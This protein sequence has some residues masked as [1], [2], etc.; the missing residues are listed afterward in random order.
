MKQEVKKAMPMIMLAFVLA[1]SMQEA[2]NIS[3]PLIIKDYAIDSAAVSMIAAVAMLTMGV[4]YVFYTALSDYISIKKLLIIGTLISAV[5]SLG[6][7]FLSQSFIWLVIFRA[8]QMAGGTSASALLI[9]TATRYLDVNTRMKY[10][11]YNTAC[12]SGG[13]IV[14]ILAGG[15]FASYLEWKYLLILPLV[16]II[17]I[18]FVIKYLPDDAG[19]GKRKIDFIGISLLAGLSLLI[20]LYFNL[21]NTNILLLAVV[22]AVVFLLY[23]SKNNNAFITIDFFKNKSYMLVML[24]VLVTYITQGSYSFLFSFMASNIHQIQ[25]SQISM[26]LLPSYFVSMIIGI[27]GGRITQKVGVFP[28]L[29][30]GLGSMFVGLLIGSFY[31]DKSLIVLLLVSTLFNGGFSILYTPVMTL[32]MDSLP[33]SMRGTGLGFFNLCIKITSSSGIVITG[34]MLASPSLQKHSIIQG[35]SQ[36]AVVYSNVLLAFLLMTVIS[37][38]TIN[39]GKRKQLKIRK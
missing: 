17:T 35:V 34:R 38:L 1:G 12:F 27:F 10:Y 37:I 20:S 15:L 26:V 22:L 5:G 19:E 8:I 28:T 23:I 25:P 18:P 24:I 9:L 39:L 31:L 32:V 29:N 4:S 21:M 3:A 14:G 2:L 6:A 30:L 33:E 13:Q 11:G 36:S 16:S 7:V